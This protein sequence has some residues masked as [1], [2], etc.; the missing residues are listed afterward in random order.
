M[1]HSPT[2]FQYSA[3]THIMKTHTHMTPHI[4]YIHP[5]C[6]CPMIEQGG[7]NDISLGYH[8]SLFGRNTWRLSWESPGNLSE[9]HILQPYPR[10]SESETLGTG[11]R[12]LCFKHS[13][14]GSCLRSTELSFWEFHFKH[15]SWEAFAP[16]FSFLNLSRPSSKLTSSFNLPGTPLQEELFFLLIYWEHFIPH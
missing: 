15:N 7:C 13:N 5:F 3:S 14:E 8:T 11:A 6:S 2:L 9:I 10:L 1:D 16:I 12:N 4:S